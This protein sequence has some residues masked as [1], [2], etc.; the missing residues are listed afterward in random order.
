MNEKITDGIRKVVEKLTG[1]ATPI[2]NI[3]YTAF[4]LTVGTDARRQRS[5]PTKLSKY[6]TRLSLSKMLFFRRVDAFNMIPLGLRR[7]LLCLL[8]IICT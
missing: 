5:S 7:L 6:D 1:Y 8:V 3:A 2:S 4:V